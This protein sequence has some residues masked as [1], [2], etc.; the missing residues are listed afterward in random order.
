MELHIRS[1]SAAQRPARGA[2]TRKVAPWPLRP[3]GGD[4]GRGSWERASPAGNGDAPQS[5][6][7]TAARLCGHPRPLHGPSARAAFTH[8]RCPGKNENTPAK[9]ACPLTR[10]HRQVWV[11]RAPRG[12]RLP[13]A[14]CTHAAGG[15]RGRLPVPW[16]TGPDAGRTPAQ[17]GPPGTRLCQTG[18]A[19]EIS[20]GM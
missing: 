5:P 13:P 2:R 11:G 8:E 20:H 4:T 14:P 7:C 15:P 6:V 18:A 9:G 16:E 12:T 17:C 1:S 3:G 10:L 19:V